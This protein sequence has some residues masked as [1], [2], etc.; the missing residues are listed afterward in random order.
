MIKILTCIDKTLLNGRLPSSIQTCVRLT[1]AKFMNVVEKVST[2][3]KD[4]LRSL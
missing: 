4:R 1:E 3:K 2:K